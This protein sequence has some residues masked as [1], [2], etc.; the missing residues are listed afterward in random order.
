LRGLANYLN[1]LDEHQHFEIFLGKVVNYQRRVAGFAASAKPAGLPTYLWIAA[2]Q[3]L[4]RL[5][6]PTLPAMPRQVVMF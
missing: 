4:W 3:L 6:L 1:Q 5:E 2:S